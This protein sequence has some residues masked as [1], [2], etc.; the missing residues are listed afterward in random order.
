MANRMNRWRWQAQ[1]LMERGGPAGVVAVIVGALAFAA[2]AAPG[3]SMSAEARALASDNDVLQRRAASAPR[4][5]SAPL[6]S[7]QQLVAFESG[8]AGSRDLGASYARLWN[9]ARRHGIALRQAEFKLTDGAQDELQRYTI[10]VPLTADYAS[11]RAFV[12]DA[13]RDQP[14]LALEEMNVR[15][16]D[17]KSLQVEARLNLVLFVRRGGA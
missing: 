10:L 2:W 16:G 11:L 7:Q 9:L 13:L 14:G 3:L 17:S 8:F 1:H 5:A 6:D 12:I 15:R 4:T